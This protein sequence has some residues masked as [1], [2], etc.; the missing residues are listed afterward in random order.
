MKKKLTKW[1]KLLCNIWMV[2]LTN[3]TFCQS[4]TLNQVFNKT[5]NAIFKIEILD[6]NNDVIKIGTGFFISQNGIGISNYHVFAGGTSARIKTYFGKTYQVIKIISWNEKSDL[7]KFQVNNPNNII[8]PFL[9]KEIIPSQIGEKVIVIGNPRGLNNSMTDGIISSFRHDYDLGKI[10]QISVP[11]SAGNSGSP[12]INLKGNYIGVISFSLKDGQNLNFAISSFEINKLI[13][14][15]KLTFPP[16][17]DDIEKKQI[18]APKSNEDELN[19]PTIWHSWACEYAFK[20][21]EILKSMGQ[22]KQITEYINNNNYGD[23]IYSSIAT[24]T[25]EGWILTSALAIKNNNLAY[26]ITISVNSELITTSKFNIKFSMISSGRPKK[27][28]DGDYKFIPRESDDNTKQDETEIV[29]DDKTVLK[30]IVKDSYS[31][32]AFGLF[33]KDG[34]RLIYILDKYELK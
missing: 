4:N 19:M 11:I 8:F 24:S 34:G 26:A 2:L 5:K 3:Q 22:G 1:A 10:I 16:K 7:I 6:E 20:E 15:N 12:L 25:K 27:L 28:V 31:L 14:V 17:L 13:L 18:E 32:Y 21:I 23:K 30:I 29:I 9:Q 33:S